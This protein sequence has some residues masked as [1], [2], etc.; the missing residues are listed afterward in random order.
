MP[1]PRADLWS[2]GVDETVEVNQRALIDKIL[3]RY[4]GEHT[5]FRELLQ[6]ADDARAEHVQ[7]KFYTQACLDALEGGGGP[8]RLPNAKKDQIVR[9]VVS[10][11]GIPFRAQDWQRLKKIAEGNPDEEKIGAFGVGFY[12]L[13]SV[14]DDPFV[15]SGDKWMGFYWKDG[16]DQLLARSGD[17]PPDPSTSKVEPSSTGH[18]WTTFIMTLREPTLLEGPLDLARFLITSLTF[19]RTVKKIDMLVDDI[20]V[21]EVAKDV[22]GKDRV[23]KRGLKTSSAGGMMTITGVDATGMVIKAKVR[24]WL[25]ATGFT[26][27]IAAPIALPSLS[28]PTKALSNF[29]SSSFFSRSSPAPAPA[30]PPAPPE[31][32]HDPMETTTL[33]REIQIYQAEIKVSV[34]TSFGRELERATKKPPPKTMPASLVFSRGE[35]EQPT[36]DDAGPSAPA[37]D[38][39]RVFE[40]LC[41]SLDS[42]Q[43]AKV[44]IGQAT[45]QTT[46]IGGHLAARFIPTVERES[47]DL[48]DRHVSLWNKELLWI[49]GYLSRLVYELEFQDLQ[50][51]WSTTSVS[52]EETRQQL[53]TRGLHTLRF[54][55]FRPTTP[56]AMV[57]QG[58]E[59][60]FFD[61]STDN[62]SLPMLSTA[63][64]L[65]VKEVRLPNA[66][67]QAFLP[68]LPVITPRAVEAASRTVARLR[69][70]MLLR[71]VILEDVV[72]QLSARPLTEEEMTLCL[73]WWQKVAGVDGYNAPMR[74]RLLDAAVMVQE[75]GKVVPL[76]IV[77]TFIKPQSSSIPT[78]MPLPQHTIPYT[79]TKDLKGSSIY[80][81]FGWTELSLVQYITFLITPPM[82]EAPGANP[83]TDIRA[84][85]AFA[86]RVLALMGRAWQSITCIPTK[87]GFKRPSEAYFEKNLLFDDLPTLAFPKNTAIRGGMEKMLLG[88]GVRKTVDL[89]LVFSRL[90]GGGSWTCQDLMKY[91]V[92]VKDTL[93]SEELARLRQT[94]AFPLEVETV[95]GQDKAPIARRKPHQL[96]EPTEAMRNLGMPLLDWGDGKWRSNSD[97][98]KMLFSLGLRKY[99]PIDELLGVA[100]GRPPTSERALVYLL[101]N[102]NVH[103]INFDPS[104]FA[105]VAFLPAT[106]PTGARVLAK[107]GEVFS[108][109][110]CAILGFAIAE[111]FIAT[112]E[113]SAKLRIATDPPMEKLVNALLSPPITDIVKAR[114][115]F[116]YLSTRIGNSVQSSIERLQSASFIP[117]KSEKGVYLAKPF[118]VYFVPK[119]GSESPYKSSFTFVDFGERGN[120]F[121]RYCGVRSEP[122]VKDVARLLL[123]DPQHML[124][125]AGSPDK[126]LD[127]LRLLAA[128]WT[129]F[130]FGIRSAMKSAAFVLA[131]QR[132]PVKSQSKKMFGSWGGSEEEYSREWVLAKASD[133]ALND[134]ITMMQYFGKQIL[135]APEEQLLE[136]FYEHLGAKSLSSLVKTEYI[137]HHPVQNTSDQAKQLCRHVLERLTIFLA[138]ARRKHSDYSVEQLSKDGNF[139]VA[140]VRELEARYTYRQGKREYNH[141]EM[142]YATA[143]THA[144]GKGIILTV[145][146]TAQPDDYDIAS[147]LCS[148]LLKSP[149]ADDALL[150]YSILSTPL[151][152]LK[153]RGFN[154]DRILN[155]Q[156]EEKLRLKAESARD[157]EKAAAVAAAEA[158]RPPPPNANGDDL[159]IKSSESR[160]TAVDKESFSNS[161]K[162]R[163]LLNKLKRSGSKDLQAGNIPGAFPGMS[164]IL[165]SPS[166]LSGAMNGATAVHGGGTSTQTTKRPTD[167]QSIR[168]TVEKAINASRPEMGT[169][170]RDSRQAVRDVSESQEEYCDA[171]AQADIV[172]AIDPGRHGLKIWVPRDIPD[173]GQFLQDKLAICQRFCADILLPIINVYNLAPGVMNI[174][175][176]HEGPLIAFNR[177]G[178][179]FCNA[180][181]FSAWHDGPVQ[182]GVKGDAFIS[183]YFSIAHEL[184]H[185]LESAH[186]ASHEFYFSSIAEEYLV[187]FAELLRS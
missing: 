38:V 94:A 23:I 67:I 63:G 69:D 30:P 88:I 165:P 70:Q 106:T 2:S 176:D 73:K 75:S 110:A 186:N 26:P 140:E 51:L 95:E 49:G 135:A 171:S 93:T 178:S 145:S 24:Q 17:L 76:S 147:A 173:H 150:L 83:E 64:V 62:K 154:V 115:V 6:N 129:N 31:P 174:F 108:N 101:A 152:A 55:S 27:P 92:S 118:E 130:D 33:H 104:A 111:P 82:S 87:A 156:R 81:V 36:P 123:R 128:N 148:I 79:V 139:Q 57:G 122:S 177:A 44:F 182:N 133:V 22:K 109:K 78:D 29:L 161:S 9:Y 89:Q 3:A 181:Y 80:D 20:K 134:N 5:I 153:K 34:T 21:L 162:T 11:D 183:W 121:L 45:S 61:C 86:E 56:S 48:V 131:S 32:V 54:F 28:K 159:S 185:N 99:P 46:G 163:S 116:E 71:D 126:Y 65:P 149:K 39:G 119:D 43:S 41:P 100:A 1:P 59:S 72:K 167:L 60:A 97:E 127:Q 19:M 155:Q 107:P 117:V 132:V 40:G 103:Y 14:C 10:N 52:D 113:N 4:S 112:P 84:S 120:L 50:L 91:L 158:P 90:V 137:P 15:E 47:I 25:A 142:L 187:R 175:W 125:Q 138:E 35:S 53:I 8:S 66:E 102:L 157:R 179:I 164:G 77:Q 141:R 96:Y 7:V 136:T 42:D 144:R 98:A 172:L 180:R 169:Q 166:G 85:P 13:W 105:G 160:D 170:I 143:W 68:D 146:L 114:A 16:K 168:N 124:E 18:P 37:K 184:A 58:M 151:M 12:S 74:A